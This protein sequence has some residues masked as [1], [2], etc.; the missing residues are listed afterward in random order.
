VH[1]K[2]VLLA[3]VVHGIFCLLE[4]IF[5]KSALLK[6]LCRPSVRPSVCLSVRLSPISQPLWHL[7][8]WNFQNK[9][10]GLQ[11][12]IVRSWILGPWPRSPEI[13]SQP[14]PLPW[15]NDFSSITRVPVIRIE[16]VRACLKGLRSYIFNIGHDGTLSFRNFMLMVK[17]T[18]KY[19]LWASWLYW[20]TA[21]IRSKSQ[22]L[23]I[24]HD[25][26]P[27]IGNF[28]LFKKLIWRFNYL[29]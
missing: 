5:K 24:G 19:Q 1:P 27:S 18:Q 14:G 13:W 26:T 10:I 11:W 7:E 8:S 15:K 9:S 22:N 25:D 21:M 3:S 2:N 20:P 12:L 4:H 23:N 28:M 6:S 16:H 17:Q 29:I